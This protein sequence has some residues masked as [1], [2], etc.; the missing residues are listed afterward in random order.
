MPG[1]ERNMYC[2]SLGAYQMTM[3]A[4]EDTARPNEFRSAYD[5]RRNGSN[6]GDR[7]QSCSNCPSEGWTG[8][9]CPFKWCGT[10]QFGAKLDAGSCAECNI[11]SWGVSF[12][13]YHSDPRLG[14]LYTSRKFRVHFVGIN[15]LF[16]SER[17]NMDL[18][19][20]RRG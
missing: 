11:S 3:R 17:T 14:Y 15:A 20:V 5:S 13:Q 12:K 18:Q 16:F 4:F 8:E 6:C 10:L 19:F 2:F 9:N 7:N 1:G